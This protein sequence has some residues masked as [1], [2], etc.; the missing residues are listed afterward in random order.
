MGNYV[1]GMNHAPWR[2]IAKYYIHWMKTGSPPA[3]TMDQVIFWHRVHPKDALCAG[4]SSTGI[5]NANYPDDAVFAWALVKDKSTIS[6]SIGS[7]QYWT[8]DADGSGPAMGM[9]PFPTD[10]S[11][12]GC[13]PEVSIM[14][15]GQTIETGK[16]SKAVSSYCEYQNFNPVV[17]LVGSGINSG[18]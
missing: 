14:R 12:D 9:V 18:L 2:I 6:M 5:R 7:N 1:W 3:I 4:G 8:F 13:T 15:N 10:V 11:Y 17:N 16:S